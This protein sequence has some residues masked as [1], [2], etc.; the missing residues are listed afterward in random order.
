M[1]PIIVAAILWGHEW[2]SKKIMIYSD[3][4]AVVNIINKRR[5]TCLDI[6]KFMRR[7]TLTSA[8]YGF[9]LAATH[10]P[11]HLNNAADAL[12]RFQFQRFKL[13]KPDANPLPTPVPPFS[14]T[15]Y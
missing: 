4:L 9:I 2:T 11:G 8:Q 14:A 5:S 13:F 3:N 7:L 1:Y 10:L 12:S 6:M 15:V